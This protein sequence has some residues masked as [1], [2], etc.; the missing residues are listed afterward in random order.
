MATILIF[1]TLKQNISRIV[2]PSVT[3]LEIIKLM[4]FG[5]YKTPLTDSPRSA[6][7]K[8]INIIKNDV[9]KNSRLTKF[10]FFSIKIFIIAEISDIKKYPIIK[11]YVPK[12]LGRNNM[13]NIKIDDEK[14]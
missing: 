14:T 4:I 7:N 2:E 13:H 1:P 10:R 3:M 5:K 11:A 6:E 8:L 12:Y 9:F